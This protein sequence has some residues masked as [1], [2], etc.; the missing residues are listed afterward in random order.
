MSPVSIKTGGIYYAPDEIIQLPEERL[1]AAGSRTLHEGRPFLVMQGQTFCDDLDY[2][3]V[4]G[5]PD[6]PYSDAAERTPKI[7]HHDDLS[8]AHDVR[9]W[10]LKRGS[11]PDYRIVLAGYFDEHKSLLKHGWRFHN[12]S[13]AGGY[14]NS[15]KTKNQNRH[16]EALFFSPACLETQPTLF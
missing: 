5:I 10:C 16:K 15:G 12:W 3:L 14:S 11:N 2:P 1:P 13:A 6:P 9:E 4:L 8:V 7:Y